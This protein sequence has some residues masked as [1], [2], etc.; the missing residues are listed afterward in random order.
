MEFLKEVIMRQLKHYRGQSEVTRRPHLKIKA[1]HASSQDYNQSIY[2][3]LNRFGATDNFWSSSGSE[4]QDASEH[5]TYQIA[6]TGGSASQS[7]TAPAVA[8]DLGKTA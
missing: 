2:C 1:V 4:T 7:T 6:G 5:L 3:T 8:F